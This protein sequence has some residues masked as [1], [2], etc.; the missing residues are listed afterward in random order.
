[1]NP[2]LVAVLLL[3]LISILIF[4]LI[5]ILVLGSIH[6]LQAIT[7]T[8]TIHISVH[9]DLI[10][11]LI[12]VSRLIGSDNDHFITLSSDDWYRQ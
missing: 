8:V 6:V 9:S 1:M 5:T 11:N 10:S 12:F 4:Q 3:Q 2:V 7:I